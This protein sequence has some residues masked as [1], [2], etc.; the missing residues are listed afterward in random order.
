MSKFKTRQGV[1]IH[2]LKE[3][4]RKWVE[5]KPDVEIYIGCDSQQRDKKINYGVSVCLYELGKGGHVIDK[6][7]VENLKENNRLRLW[8]EVEKSVEVADEL[9]D[10]GIKIVVHVDYNSDPGEKSENKSNEF[11]E[12]GIGYAISRGYEAAGKPNAWAATYCADKIVKN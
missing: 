12:S 9:R 5:D 11:Y 7:I 4:V 8:E 3:Y 1:I 10:L 2:D 6:L